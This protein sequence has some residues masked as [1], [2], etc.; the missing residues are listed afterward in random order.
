MGRLTH[1]LGDALRSA[2]IKHG[3]KIAWGRVYVH[4]DSPAALPVIARVF[5]ISSCSLVDAVVPANV[6]AITE[7]GFE[8]F[9]DR[10][11][12]KRY[13]VRSHRVGNHSFKS[14]DVEMQLGGALRP[15]A[16]RVD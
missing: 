14:H 6:T 9:R 16:E 11:A 8:L 4:V 13:A 12:G 3:I 10:V 1:N 15:F 7:R 5:G 2:G